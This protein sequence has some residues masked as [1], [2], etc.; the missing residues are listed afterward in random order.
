[1]ADIVVT[2]DALGSETTAL[3]GT[4]AASFEIDGTELFLQAGTALDALTDSDLEVTVEVDDTS[5]GAGADDSATLN[6]TVTDATAPTVTLSSGAADPTNADPFQVTITFSEEVQNF[7]VSDITLGNGSAGNLATS[8]DTVFTADISPSSDGTVTVDVGAAVAEDLAG[9]DNEAATQLSR[10]YDGTAP[11]AAF[12]ASIASPTNGSSVVFDVV[13]SEDVTGVDASDFAADTGVFTGTVGSLG[14]GNA[15]DSDDATYTVTINSVS[16]DGD[17]GLEFS[18]PSITDVA[19]NGV[20]TTPTTDETVT[21]DQTAPAVSVDPVE[22]T[23]TTPPLSGTVDD[24]NA[25][26]SVTV[27]G[28]THP[29]TNNGATWTLADNTLT[30]LALGTFDVSVTA[31]DAAGNVGN[32]ATTDELEILTA[33]EDW[34]RDNF[35]TAELSD[36]TIS[37]P[38][39]NPDGD[40]R[41]NIF[42]F[43]HVSD[44]KAFDT[45]D[46]VS[47]ELNGSHETEWSFVRRIDRSGTTLTVRVSGNPD[48]SGAT[49]LTNP[50]LSVIDAESETATY[51]DD[52]AVAP[53]APRYF[54]IEITVD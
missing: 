43:L 14:V 35:T 12:T 49:V 37:G 6:I 18:L 22:T 1:V 33:W 46:P 4:D 42:E 16:G 24:A 20:N 11:T 48:M 8:D 13:F 52:T 51:T 50:A 47:S 27:D 28:Q 53:D 15:G 2:D 45:G 25:T 21:V 30:A 31:T 44:P 3:A 23:D 7:A 40:A 38:D 10:D 32:D 19:G 54:R 29:A 34:R 36:P 17:L 5:L 41:D 39:A 26:I 9:N